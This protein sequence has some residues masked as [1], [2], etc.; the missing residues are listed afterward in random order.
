MSAESWR[1]VR[2][3]EGYY[4]VSDQGRVRGLERTTNPYA[5]RVLRARIMRPTVRKDNGRLEVHLNRE[6]RSATRRV[7][8]LVVE[9]FSGPKPFPG[10][11]AR[12]MNGIGTD[13]RAENL[14]WGT[15]SENNLDTIWHA[16]NPGQIRPDAIERTER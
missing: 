15:S 12:H 3:Y 16:E 6:G 13:N 5:P 14:R 7:H 1:P 2:G 10:A 9:A 8:T 4:E 11:V